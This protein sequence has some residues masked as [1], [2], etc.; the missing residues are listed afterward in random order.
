MPLSYHDEI[1]KQTNPLMKTTIRFSAFRCFLKHEKECG[2]WLF[3]V[4]NGV[5]SEGM[6]VYMF[7]RTASHCT[8]EDR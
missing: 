2:V 7:V 4:F 3:S 1:N 8:V 6:E 5:R